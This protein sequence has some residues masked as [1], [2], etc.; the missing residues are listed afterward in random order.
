MG[1]KI[2]PLPQSQGLGGKQRFYSHTL[3]F[4]HLAYKVAQARQGREASPRSVRTGQGRE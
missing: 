4:F 1:G 2:T 3:Q